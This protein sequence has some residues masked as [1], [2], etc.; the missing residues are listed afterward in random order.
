[1]DSTKTAWLILLA[2]FI[3]FNLLWYLADGFA[4][5][6]KTGDPILVAIGY[7][8]TNPEHLAIIFGMTTIKKIR[9]FIASLFVVSALDI[10]S[11]A[12]FI[13]RACVLPMD[14]STYAGL[15]TIVFR[16]SLSILGYFPLCTYGLYVILCTLLLVVALEIAYPRS[17]VSLVKKAVGWK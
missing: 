2:F 8:L 10:A 12:H 15:D 7:M 11:W 3:L 14:P 13:T 16:F 5:W 17:F 6:A 9:G 1:M 4:E